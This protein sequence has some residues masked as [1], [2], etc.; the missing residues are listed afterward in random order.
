MVG[1]PTAREVSV[2]TVAVLVED[3]EFRAVFVIDYRKLTGSQF[4]TAP[5]ALTKQRRYI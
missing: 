4:S 3:G 2:R 5:S 1:T